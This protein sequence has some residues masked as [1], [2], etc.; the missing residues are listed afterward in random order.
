MKSTCLF[1]LTLSFVNLHLEAN[2]LLRAEG[3]VHPALSSAGAPHRQE[4][5][6][7]GQAFAG[8]RITDAQGAHPATAHRW[9]RGHLGAASH[10]VNRPKQLPNRRQ[11]SPAGNPVNLGQ[12]GP[13][14]FAAVAKSGFVRSET[15]NNTLTSRAPS[16]VRPTAPSFSTGRHRSPNPAVVAGAPNSHSSNAAALNGTR[17]TRRP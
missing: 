5:G 4:Q 12:P 2:P 11:G 7:A 6:G 8:R 3:E 15:V 16:V 17:M 13:S 14:K 9:A 1:L 10:K